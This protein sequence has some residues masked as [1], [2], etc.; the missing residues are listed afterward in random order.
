MSDQPGFTTTFAVEQSPKEVFNAINDVRRWW[1]GSIEGEALER[2]DVFSYRYEPFHFS[3]QEV[4]ELVPDEKVVWRVID[5]HLKGAA[6]PSEWTGTDIT[7]DIIAL[8]RGTEVRFSHVG[9]VPAFE[10]F[11]SCSGGWDFFIHRSLRHLIAT[12][13]GPASPPWA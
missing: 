7:F 9:L 6:D 3:S 5:S 8:E 1:T 2:G 4:I 12:G 11:E 10:C 13:E